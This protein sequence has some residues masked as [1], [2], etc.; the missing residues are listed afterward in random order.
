MINTK[1][2]VFLDSVLTL[3]LLLFLF[4]DIQ[5]YKHRTMKI[6]SILACLCISLTGIAQKTA[7]VKVVVTNVNGQPYPG[8]KIL[9]VGQ[10]KHDT[11]SGITN[12]KGE[13][14]IQLPEGQVYDI[15][16]K[17][18]GTEMEY[19]ELEIPALPA[20]QFYTENTLTITYEM[21]TEY[22]LSQL[23]F[24]TGK[25]T[26]KADSY[27][28]LD[29]L[30]DMMKRKSTWNIQISGHTDS[31]GDDAANLVLSQ[32]RADAVKQYLVSKGIS[33]A[34][35]RSIGYGETKPIANNSTAEGKAQNRRTEV[36]IVSK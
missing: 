24:E 10:T 26:L 2:I 12:S 19:N 35:V 34:R 22:V 36:N 25:A 23:H 31:D 13:F 1:L 16:V 28:L 27:A 21:P 17:S 3:I 29:D 11:Y 7:P 14:I 20:D 33:A 15:R 18:I 32:Q 5:S 8:D 6:R 4:A 9:F 30:L